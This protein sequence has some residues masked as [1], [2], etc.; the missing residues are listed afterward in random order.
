MGCTRQAQEVKLAQ[1][2]Y[3]MLRNLN[4]YSKISEEYTGL[5]KSVSRRIIP[6]SI[7][8]TGL[9]IRTSSVEIC[10]G[11]VS[12]KLKQLFYSSYALHRHSR[13]S[14]LLGS[15]QGL[16]FHNTSLALYTVSHR[17]IKGLSIIHRQAGTCVEPKTHSP[18]LSSVCIL[19]LKAFS[20]QF[21][22]VNIQFLPIL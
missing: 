6:E 13:N 12:N 21:C 11:R 9:M 1:E 18:H 2:R 5:F 14:T 10:L 20:T 4:F 3:D 15:S 16:P 8:N 19:H 7:T 17:S 22:L